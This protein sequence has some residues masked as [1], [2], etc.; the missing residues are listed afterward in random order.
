MYFT[1]YEFYIFLYIKISIGIQY[2]KIY[3]NKL[4]KLINKK[5]IL[6][7]NI[8]KIVSKIEIA[9]IHDLQVQLEQIK[10]DFQPA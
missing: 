5:R 6:V 1:N 8:I 3:N 4:I 10:H 7:K 2:Y 9:P